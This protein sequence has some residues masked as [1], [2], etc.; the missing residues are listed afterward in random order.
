MSITTSKKYPQGTDQIHKLLG[1][2]VKDVPVTEDIHPLDAGVITKKTSTPIEEKLKSKSKIDLENSTHSQ[3]LNNS[4][5]NL[6]TDAPSLD[7]NETAVNPAIKIAKAVFPY[8]LVFVVGLVGYFFFFSKIDFNKILTS[9]PKA[10]VLSTKDSMIKQLETQNMDAYKKWIS[11]YYFEVTD[12]K[13]IDP[14]ADNSGNGLTN[15]Q[16]FLLG[17]NPKSYDTLGL[18]MADSEA[19]SQGISPQTGSPL[20]E[21]EKKNLEKYID[22]EVVMGRFSLAVSRS[23]NNIAGV[24]TN[25]PINTTQTET[26]KVITPRSGMEGSSSTQDL[27]PILGNTRAVNTGNTGANQIVSQPVQ[28]PIKPVAPVT[29]PAERPA[30]DNPYGVEVDQ[31][32]AGRLEIPDLKINV[33]II[34]TKTPNDFLTDLQS[35]VVHYPGTALPG[36]V[37]TTYIS[38]H[39]SNYIWAK[40]N[41]NSIFA[42]LGNLP[43]NTSF[44]ITVVQKNGKDAILHYVVTK[45]KEYSPRDAE[46]FRNTDKS[47]VA[48]STCWPVG[49]TQ[50]RLVVFGELTQVEK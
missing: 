28:Q 47:L 35:G 13:I 41:Y 4:H 29:G 44:K 3:V 39:S 12:P 16:K 37:G 5:A 25:T 11:T 36:E 17:L 30:L 23:Q 6:H 10:V 8:V 24:S 27:S 21:E 46:Q 45:R 50:K 2:D 15:F 48:L 38:G 26:R 43:D 31:S 1:L 49:T 32:V 7:E 9:K 19:L 20:T 22:M 33:P 40:G 14:D 18:G 34:W 42:K